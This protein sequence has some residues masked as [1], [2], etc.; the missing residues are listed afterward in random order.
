MTAEPGRYPGLLRLVLE[1][2]TGRRPVE[3]SGDLL[4]AFLALPPWLRELVRWVLRPRRRFLYGRLRALSG[5]RVMSGPFVGMQLAGEPAAPELLGTYERELAA[6]VRALAARSF[7]SIV[8]VGARFGYYA[9]GFAR[10]MPHARVLAFE[11]EAEARQALAGC[12]RANGVA[13]RVTV[14]GFCDIPELIDALGDGTDV[15][16]VCDIE[17]GEAVLL[18]PDRVPALGRVTILVECHGLAE[19][20]TERL[21][22]ARFLPTHEVQHIATETR[23]LAHL[24]PGVAEPWRSRLPATTEALMQEHRH[25]QQSWLV[26]SPRP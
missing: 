24:P 22:V 15:L 20:F 5:D 1:T 23:V 3:H 4:N 14:G 26:L 9:I 16:L 17:G 8:N 2:A 10:L 25:Q 12:A 18:D 13:E 7:R 21:L 6:V 19:E 11:A